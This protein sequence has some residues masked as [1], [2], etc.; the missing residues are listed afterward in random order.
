MD[1]PVDTA[2]T[3]ATDGTDG[4]DA[5]DAPE[6]QVVDASRASNA[7]GGGYEVLGSP[8]ERWVVAALL[9]AAWLLAFFLIWEQ[10]QTKKR[11]AAA[12]AQGASAAVALGFPVPPSM[13][14]GI[15][16]T[17]ATAYSAKSGNGLAAQLAQLQTLSTQVQTLTADANAMKI[18]AINVASEAPPPGQTITTAAGV[19]ALDIGNDWLAT[20]SNTSFT[21]GKKNMPAHT[22][23]S[24]SQPEVN[25]TNPGN[26]LVSVYMLEVSRVTP[27][28][29]TLEGTAKGTFPAIVANGDYTQGIDLGMQG[30]NNKP[31]SWT[32]QDGWFTYTGDVSL[33][34]TQQQAGV[35]PQWHIGL[36]QAT[37]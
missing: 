4:T 5:T 36:T 27:P 17:P 20:G 35:M 34:N 13:Q 8:A 32:Q 14:Q 29:Q 24:C 37:D 2:A 21:I 6:V 28:G 11:L 18:M 19:K 22:Q 9:V 16:T 12:T 10:V 26:G 7:L 15:T 25:V 31:T 23:F 30:W 1:P 33:Y 3:D